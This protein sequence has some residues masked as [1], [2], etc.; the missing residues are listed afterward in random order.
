MAEALREI[1][2]DAPVARF[3]GIGQSAARNRLGAN[4]HVIELQRVRA[5]A[6][7]DLA[8]A[9]PKC[10]LRKRHTEELIETTE[11]SDSELALIP[12]DAS[13]K[14]RQRQM[15]RQL[16]EHQLAL[17][18]RLPPLP[19]GGRKAVLSSNRDQAK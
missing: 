4:T 19:H 7:L 2:I 6:C 3:V 17:V 16:R 18:H 12:S 1:G 9:L 8:Q 15:L 14:R 5:K 10:E 11:R 13:P